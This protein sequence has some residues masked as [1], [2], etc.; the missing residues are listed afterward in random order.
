MRGVG[1][2]RASREV[3]VKDLLLEWRTLESLSS[4]LVF[5]L[6]VLV[7][8]SFAFGFEAVRELGAHR[9]VPGVVWTVLAFAA[10]VGMTRSMMIE[11]KRAS[12]SA[13]FL[14]PI[15][16]GAIFTGKLIANLVKLTLL[17]WIIVPLSAV[18]FDLRRA[19]LSKPGGF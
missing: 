2:I 9:L 1:F 17:Q 3:A 4:T 18:F 10:V 7:I 16:R 11:N 19:L 5:S 15:D 6:V 12:M 8:F 13:L 14:A